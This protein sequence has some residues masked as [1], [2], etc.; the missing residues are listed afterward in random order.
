MSSAPLPVTE[1][2]AMAQVEATPAELQWQRGGVLCCTIELPA[3]DTPPTDGWCDKDAVDEVYTVTLEADI[4]KPR[5]VGRGTLRLVEDARQVVLRWRGRDWEPL[6]VCPPM[7]CVMAAADPQECVMAQ[8]HRWMTWEPHDPEPGYLRVRKQLRILCR[9]R[10]RGYLDERER[11]READTYHHAPEVPS[12]SGQMQAYHQPGRKR[13]RA[14]DAP[15]EARRLAAQGITLTG[16]ERIRTADGLTFDRTPVTVTLQ[17]HAT[18]AQTGAIELPVKALHTVYGGGSKWDE[19]RQRITQQMLPGMEPRGELQELRALALQAVGDV[20]GARRVTWFYAALGAVREHR[21]LELDR[22]TGEL[23]SKVRHRVMQ[24][25]GCPPSDANARQAQEYR[26]FLHLL[27]HA[28]LRVTP[29]RGRKR[30]QLQDE[31][32]VPLLVVTATENGRSYSMQV[33]PILTDHL[34]KVPLELLRLT[35]SSD[36]EGL[37]RALGVSIITR[38]QLALAH[39]ERLLLPERLDKTL[40]RAGLLAWVHECAADTQHR[41]RLHVK[42]ELEEALDMLRELPAKR[43][44]WLDVVGACSITWG[45]GRRWLTGGK[46][47]YGSMP[48]WLVRQLPQ[49]PPSSR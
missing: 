11:A 26:D 8:H 37:V 30:G 17:L 39:P 22:D 3:D 6:V 46:L 23:P 35:D 44:A 20:L 15:P 1:E 28:S 2:A 25:T 40:E 29:H 21:M 33:N 13:Q 9:S 42:R 4:G 49:L 16:G 12:T 19:W 38:Q 45:H 47:Q 41:G 14:S 43:A 7:E 34:M 5:C 31:V 10:S 36:P 24:L 48:R 32:M 27:R 18:E